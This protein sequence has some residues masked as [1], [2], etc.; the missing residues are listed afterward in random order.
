M[1]EVPK[2]AIIAVVTLQVIQMR[3]VLQ[4]TAVTGEGV[5]VVVS[6]MV[7]RAVLNKIKEKDTY[8]DVK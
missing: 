4:Y 8:D 3:L 7:I 2:K 6:L 5:A 1:E